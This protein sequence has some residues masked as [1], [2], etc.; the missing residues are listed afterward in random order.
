MAWTYLGTYRSVDDELNAFE[1]VTL[2]TVREALARYP[3]TNLTTLAFGP[4][5]SV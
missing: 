2:D 1:A 3:V 5:E 4:L